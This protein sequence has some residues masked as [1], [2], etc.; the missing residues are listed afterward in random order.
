MPCGLVLLGGGRIGG[1]FLVGVYAG[2]VV[3]NAV[4]GSHSSGYRG[5]GGEEE[6]DVGL[7]FW[8]HR[9]S[10]PGLEVEG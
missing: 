10:I 7:D 1:Y 4:N 3:L 6:L 8:S 2:D 5:Y 9:L